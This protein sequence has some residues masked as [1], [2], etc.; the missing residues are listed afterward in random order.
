[1]RLSGASVARL[2]PEVLVS[3]PLYDAHDGQDQKH[4]KEQT[5]AA[6]GVIAPTRAVRPCGE[7]EIGRAHV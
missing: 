3:V 6:A 7:T 5:E 1:M 2:P 4:D